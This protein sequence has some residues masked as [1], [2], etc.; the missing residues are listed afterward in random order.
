MTT[1]YLA[2]ERE[3]YG[4]YRRA[5]QLA[6]GRVGEDADACDALL[7]PGGGDLEPWRY[8]QK[9]LAARDV[10]PAR[11]EWELSLLDAFVAR[12]RPV[13]GICR[14]LQVINV[15][16]GGSLI[17]HLEGHS[18]I[19]GQDR[20]HTI[21]TA[22]S[23]LLEVCGREAVVNSAHHQAADR[24]GAGLLPVQWSRDGVVEALC[25][26]T[27]PIWAVQWHPERLEGGMG[28]R[29]FRSFLSLCETTG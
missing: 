19:H 18:A 24:M 12:R 6:G 23:P 28:R 15:F 17:Q 14:G 16:F 8:G 13:L 27:M 4:N 2:G 29:L 21:R 26:R 10:D 3:K 7:L 1:V 25:H 11:D 22:P 9:A 5:I 20:R